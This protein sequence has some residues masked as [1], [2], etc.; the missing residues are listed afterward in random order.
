MCLYIRDH[1]QIVASQEMVKN[2]SEEMDESLI[3]QAY[4]GPNAAPLY[5]SKHEIELREL[6]KRLN[7]SDSGAAQAHAP[8]ATQNGPQANGS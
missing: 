4:G 7:S 8:S 1:C 2:L 3:P 6:V 5:E